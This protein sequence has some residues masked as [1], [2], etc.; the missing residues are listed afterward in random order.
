MVTPIE[1]PAVRSSLQ[2]ARGSLQIGYDYDFG[3]EKQDICNSKLKK[4]V[5]EEPLV[6]TFSKP[7][8][9]VD[10]EVNRTS[11]ADLNKQKIINDQGDIQMGYMQNE[12]GSSF[13]T[14][15]F[16][17]VGVGKNVV[18]EGLSNEGVKLHKKTTWQ[19]Q[20]Q[21]TGSNGEANTNTG[22]NI[23]SSQLNDI[24]LKLEEKRKHIENE[25]RK[26]EVA[27]SRQRQKVG[28]AAFLQ[29]V[30]VCEN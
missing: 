21:Q 28:K 16:F 13:L 2:D 30:K 19:Q 3:C 23:M 8:D 9:N 12:K 10:G 27:L 14:K 29:A 17:T 5:T 11:F 6:K 18:L 20:S 25:K 1:N 24:K 26:M 7:S 15:T 4:Q 22:Q